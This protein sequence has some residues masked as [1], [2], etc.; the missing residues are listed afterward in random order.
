M[1]ANRGCTV[2]IKLSSK[3]CGGRATEAPG[4]RRLRRPRNRRRQPLVGRTN[5]QT[6]ANQGGS[7]F[8]VPSLSFSL[9]G[10]VLEVTRCE[11]PVA[12]R[13][14]TRNRGGHERAASAWEKLVGEDMANAVPLP[15][16]HA[17]DRRRIPVVTWRCPPSSRWDAF[18]Y[19][20]GSTA[21]ALRGYDA[22][23]I[24]LRRLFG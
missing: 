24:Q 20:S 8:E 10:L 18:G 14:E 22:R 15:R 5:G 19:E 16:V 3:K 1:Q 17:R 7:T 23:T 13:P 6:A 12:P 4:A 11:P 2:G 21:C 9:S